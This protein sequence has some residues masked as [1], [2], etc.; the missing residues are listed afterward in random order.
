MVTHAAPVKGLT[1]A[2][3]GFRFAILGFDSLPFWILR[4]ALR[5]LDRLL[6][7]D[8]ESFVLFFVWTS[9]R[10]VSFL[11]TR[12]TRVVVSTLIGREAIEASRQ[13]LQ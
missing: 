9:R 5:R 3:D 6:I 8:L 13:F 12:V 10:L 2:S 4:T 1:V 11:A 7:L